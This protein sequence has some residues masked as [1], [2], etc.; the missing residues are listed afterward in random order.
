MVKGVGEFFPFLKLG[1]KVFPL[2]IFFECQ[3]KAEWNKP[4]TH[5]QCPSSVRRLYKLPDFA[6]DFLAVPLMDAPVLSLQSTGLVEEDGL[7]VIR[8]SWD[9]KMEIA[10][11]HSHEAAT[12]AIKRAQRPPL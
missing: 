6:N 2:P 8:D 4:A 10:L 1:P 5:K 12:L 7:G 11:R 9:K 3:I